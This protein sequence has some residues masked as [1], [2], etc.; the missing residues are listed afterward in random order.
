MP[1]KRPASPAYDGA[2][3]PSSRV[4]IS[5]SIHDRKSVFIGY[6]TPNISIRPKS[7]QLRND[8]KS[9]S[10]RILGWRLP[11]TQQT[12]LPNAPPVYKSGHD[13]DGEQ[14]AG[15]RVEKSMEELNIQGTI[16]VARWYGGE[17]LGPARFKHIEDVAKGAVD[18]WRNEQN[19]GSS[20]RARVDDQ[21]VFEATV[22]AGQTMT[23][24]ELSRRKKVIIT[25]LQRRDESI[26]ALRMLLEQKR[27][28]NSAALTSPQP[29]A[30]PSRVPDYTS[31]PFMRLQALE[32]ARD[33]T[34][35]F[36]LK[37]IDKAEAEAEAHAE[38]IRRK[39]VSDAALKA[40]Q[41]ADELDDAWEEMAEAM[42]HTRDPD[43]SK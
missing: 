21:G 1:P 41:D 8:T 3:S 32:T 5:E 9:A 20:K 37:S 33:N 17:L 11:S 43:D 34:I 27:N 31:M 4:Y 15:R 29:V 38:V 30:S 26:A 39:A 19:G 16:M 23:P 28:S 14:W 25:T 6:Y 36:L 24:D 10:H 2:D 18:A 13:D 40:V 22:T 35:S 42:Q 7:L 12:L